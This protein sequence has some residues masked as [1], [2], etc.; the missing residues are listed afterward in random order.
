M[1]RCSDRDFVSVNIKQALVTREYII[2]PQNVD[3]VVCKLSEDEGI[4][5]LVIRIDLEQ[6]VR[7]VREDNRAVGDSAPSGTRCRVGYRARRGSPAPSPASTPREMQPFL[8]VAPVAASATPCL[9]RTCGLLLSGASAAHCAAR[10]Q[11]PCKASHAAAAAAASMKSNQQA[12]HCRCSLHFSSSASAAGVAGWIDVIPPFIGSEV[13]HS[14]RS[15]LHALR[16]PVLWHCCAASARRAHSI[17]A[18][19]GADRVHDGTQI[20]PRRCFSALCTHSTHAVPVVTRALPWC[21]S[22]TRRRLA[23]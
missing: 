2:L 22:S 11:C 10:Q 7:A 18:F 21:R 23:E 9:A 13:G 14:G 15:L 19:R 16:P 12:L 4:S 1:P 17:V 8:H 6:C 5:W 3:L 20:T